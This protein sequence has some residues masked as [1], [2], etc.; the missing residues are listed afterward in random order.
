[1]QDDPVK[2]G[3]VGAHNRRLARVDADVLLAAKDAAAEVALSLPAFWRAVSSGRL[4]TPVYPAP[5][6]P[7]WRR[8]EL[9][10]ALEKTRAL[11]AT[12]KAARRAARLQKVTA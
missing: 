2:A 4:P 12:A 3:A 7:R 9:H 11:P 10:A 5:R 8:A 1:M 6:A